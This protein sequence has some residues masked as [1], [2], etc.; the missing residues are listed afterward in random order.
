MGQIAEL[1]QRFAPA[2]RAFRVDDA[3]FSI[4]ENGSRA[5]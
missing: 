1:C 4:C 3:L 2:A 5:G